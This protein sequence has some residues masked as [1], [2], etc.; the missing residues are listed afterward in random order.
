[1]QTTGRVKTGIVNMTKKT[2]TTKDG[3]TAKKGLYYYMNKA[4]EEG[5][6]KSGKGTV[7]D[8]ALTRSAKTAKPKKMSLGGPVESRIAKGCGAVMPNKRKKT[9]FF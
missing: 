9:K 8:E 5:R 7:T 4:K 2:H 6:R 1:M 3:R